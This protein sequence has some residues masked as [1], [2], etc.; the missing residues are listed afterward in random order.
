MPL[1]A[2]VSM[3]LMS[4]R[5]DISIAGTSK[6]DLQIVTMGQLKEVME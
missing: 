2:A 3:T 5:N 4:L 6:V 1:K